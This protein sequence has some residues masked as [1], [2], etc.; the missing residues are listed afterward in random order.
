MAFKPLAIAAVA[1]VSL[2]C[3]FGARADTPSQAGPPPGAVPARIAACLALPAGQQRASCFRNLTPT[4]VSRCLSLPT[5]AERVACFRKMVP[6]PVAACLAQPT[7]RQRTSCFKKL[8]K[9]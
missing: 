5:R 4:A 6:A 9:P 1:L 3:A 7:Q 2:A 8:R